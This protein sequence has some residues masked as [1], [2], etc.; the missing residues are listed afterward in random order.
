[1]CQKKMRHET[2]ESA[3][4]IV[5]D[6]KRKARAGNRLKAYKCPICGGFHIG[7][8]GTGWAKSNDSEPAEAPLPST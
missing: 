6:T 8:R 1:M 2:M 7:H 4:E 5:R 3:K